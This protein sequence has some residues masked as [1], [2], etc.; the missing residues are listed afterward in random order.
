MQAHL[1]SP[2]QNYLAMDAGSIVLSRRA[3]EEL[4]SIICFKRETVRLRQ[5]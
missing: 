4:L 3:D 1:C 2:S 5:E